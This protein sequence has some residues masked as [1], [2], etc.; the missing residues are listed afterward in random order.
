[1]IYSPTA[2]ILNTKYVYKCNAIVINM[3]KQQKFKLRPT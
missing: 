1:M 3:Y 2:I